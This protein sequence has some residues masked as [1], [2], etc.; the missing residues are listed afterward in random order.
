LNIFAIHGTGISSANDLYDPDIQGYV[1][2]SLESRV[3]GIHHVSAL[4]VGAA[5]GR[6]LSIDVLRHV[7][8]D[9][10]SPG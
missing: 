6:L 5:D 2:R 9:G 1:A 8:S 10:E 3:G 7:R 4:A